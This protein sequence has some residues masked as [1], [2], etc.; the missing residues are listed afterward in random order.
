MERKDPAAFERRVVRALNRHFDA[1]LVHADPSVVRLDETFSGLDAMNIPVVYTGFVA[2]G[3]DQK[4]A[5]K[6]RRNLRVRPGQAMVLASAG[7]G[8]VGFRVLEAVA[9]AVRTMETER[10][11]LFLF[12]GPHLAEEEFKRLHAFS[13][14]NVVVERFTPRIF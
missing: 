9:R 12:S 8:R 7:G 10:I 2:P 4:A 13:Q 11:R 6:L 1:L 5:E 14:E 3:P